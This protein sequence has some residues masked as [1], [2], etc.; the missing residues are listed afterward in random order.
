MAIDPK[1]VFN[2]FE[3]K[4]MRVIHYISGFFSALLNPLLMPTYG[5]CVAFWM[6]N[7]LVLTLPAKLTVM[8]V[9]FAITCILPILLFLLLKMLKVIDSIQ[10]N[11]QKERLVP[12][13]ITIV[14]YIASAIYLFSINSPDWLWMFMFGGGCAALISMIVNFKWKISAHMAGIGGFIALI[15]RINADGDGIFDLLP[16]ICVA[17]FIAGILGT[18]R[19][20][21]E[22]HTFWQVIAGTANGFICV[23]FL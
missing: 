21:M 11:R 16:M 15:C 3:A 1:L 12:Y 7:L 14:C 13:I 20:A 10:L 22:R 17:I 5:L 8:L 4:A 23:F 18:S 6:S 19:I 9:V 2:T